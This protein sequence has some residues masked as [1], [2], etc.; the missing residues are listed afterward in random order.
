[1]NFNATF[2]NG[3]FVI[4]LELFEDERG[5]FTRT[6]CKDEFKKINHDKEWVQIN[7]SF[8]KEKG[9]IRGL[10]FQL[11]PNGEIKLVRCI[12]GKIFDVVVDLRKGSPSFL[13]WFGVELSAENKKM[14][15]IPEG[16]AHG[17]LT[18][19][20]DCEVIYHHSN[21]Y[22]VS[23]EGGIN[24]RDPKLNINWPI[25][26]T[27]ISERDKALPELKENFKGLSL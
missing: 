25:A 17:F 4:G 11:P 12:S 5:W 24:Y 16:C 27:T 20:D 22:T 3:V 9:T 26:I 18:L 10:H 2:I 13:K 14:I 7:H 8:T 6:F 1:M 21:F 15:Y 23:A 19:S